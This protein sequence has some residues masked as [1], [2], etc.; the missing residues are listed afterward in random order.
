ML[1]N[2]A[3][4]HSSRQIPIEHAIA[5]LDLLFVQISEQIGTAD[6]AMEDW[7]DIVPDEVAELER[8]GRERKEKGI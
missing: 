8:R 4:T 2:E 5:V 6:D 7:R 3:A 1:N